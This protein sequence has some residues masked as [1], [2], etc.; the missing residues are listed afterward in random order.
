MGLMERA[1]SADGGS[2]ETEMYVIS[3]EETFLDTHTHTLAHS[4]THLHT[5]THTHSLTHL[6][7]CTHTDTGLQG[8]ICNVCI[9]V[10]RKHAI[11]SPPRAFG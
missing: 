9:C 11:T 1:R 10:L 4:L 3:V 5:H 6:H 8:A 2:G 7:T